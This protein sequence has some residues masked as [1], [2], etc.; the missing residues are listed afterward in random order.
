MNPSQIVY[1]KFPRGVLELKDLPEDAQIN[2]HGDKFAEMMKETHDLVKLA[3]E[4][5]SKKYK[6]AKEKHRSDVQL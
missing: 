6:Q 1:G 2:D 3:L 5:S 4:E